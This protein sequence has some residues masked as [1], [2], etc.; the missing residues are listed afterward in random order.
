MRPHFSSAPKSHNTINFTLHSPFNLPTS[1]QQ[2]QRPPETGRAAG[3]VS[4]TIFKQG[5]IHGYRRVFGAIY[6]VFVGKYL[7]DNS[8]ALN[9]GRTEEGGGCGGS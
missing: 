9:P 5:I 1:G 4:R 6:K 2:P 7:S 3:D 8:Q